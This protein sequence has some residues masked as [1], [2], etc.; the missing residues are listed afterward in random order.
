MPQ[1]DQ[2]LREDLS[3]SDSDEEG[4]ILNEVSEPAGAK[5]KEQVR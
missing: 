3:R 4:G 1:A 2:G 5:R